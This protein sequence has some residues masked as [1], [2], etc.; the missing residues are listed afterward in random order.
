MEIGIYT[1]VYCLPYRQSR[2]RQLQH[3]ASKQTDHYVV[4]ASEKGER[5]SQSGG[6]TH[7]RSCLGLLGCG[8]LLLVLLCL[9]R[10]GL[11]VFLCFLC[12]GLLVFFGLLSGS[13][14]LFLVLLGGGSL[15][16]LGLELSLFLLLLG[17]SISLGPGLSLVGVSDSECRDDQMICD[18]VLT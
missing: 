3:V 11:L 12:S 6:E 17:S 8:L 13:S 5:T 16:L 15:L 2:F 10:G 18:T 4:Q 14:L 1:S 9:L 7:D